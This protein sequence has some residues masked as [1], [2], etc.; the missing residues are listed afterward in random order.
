MKNLKWIILIAL[1]VVWGS[2]FILMKRGLEAFSSTQVAAL[3]IGF[4]Y[5]FLLPFLI[6]Y[7]Q[8]NLKKYWKGLIGMG[9]FG[10]LIPAFL[11]TK[12][13]TGISSSLAGMLNA[14]TPLFTVVV[15]WIAFRHRSNIFQFLG[16]IIGFG[17]ALLLLYSGK[18]GANSGS[19][20][21]A[22]MVVAATFC[23]AI[24]VNMIRKYLSQMNS[25]RATVWA[26]MFTGP[27]SLIY[28]F[29]TNFFEVVNTHPHA[30]SSLGYIAILGIVGSAL[31]VIAFNELI[32]MSNPVFASTTTYLIPVT[33]VYWGV[34]DGE[35]I[36]WVQVA[37]IA[38][39]LAAIWLVNF[40]RKTG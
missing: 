17:G 4:A 34:K 31:S 24:S 26:F 12:A 8:I 9:L 7:Y 18:A 28:L 33:A 40:S 21:F 20:K 29:S 39:I 25:T 32:K 1:S 38:V 15:G 23:Y 13:E 6:K 37:A 5:I 16:I 22:L 14:L 36:S 3:R 11:F 30:A 35:T 10:N 27:V 19:A 2:S